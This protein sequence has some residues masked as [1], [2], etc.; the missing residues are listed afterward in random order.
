MVD[1]HNDTSASLPTSI[2][3]NINFYEYLSQFYEPQVIGWFQ[4]IPLHISLN[5]SARSTPGQQKIATQL[6]L[7]ITLVKNIYNP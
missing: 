4:S 7:A 5:A 1:F 2:S 3:A 6:G